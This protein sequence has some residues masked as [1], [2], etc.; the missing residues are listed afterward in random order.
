M[1]GTLP[2]SSGA[3]WQ[4]P[5]TSSSCLAS[6]TAATMR[7]DPPTPT[8]HTTTPPHPPQV[9]LS[10][11]CATAERF[12]AVGAVLSSM[13]AGLAEQ[14]SVRLLKHIIRCYLRLRCVCVCGGGRGEGGS[15][16]PAEGGS[17]VPRCYWRLAR[18]WEQAHNCGSPHSRLCAGS[19]SLRLGVVAPRPA[20]I[21]TSSPLPAPLPAATTR[22]RARRCA[23]A[24]PTCCATRSSPPASRTTSPRAA[25]WRRCAA[26]HP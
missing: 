15:C 25:G 1:P 10:Y 22:G 23:S 7:V 11:I 12:F 16:A 9:G 2:A 6:T 26:A 5:S 4:H 20:S 3:P 19:L 14:P 24:C 8:T 21:L 18:C 17:V 13:V